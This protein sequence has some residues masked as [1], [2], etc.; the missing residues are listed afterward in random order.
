[1]I[2]AVLAIPGCV[3]GP[4]EGSVVLTIGK[5]QTVQNRGIA[6]ALSALMILSVVAVGAAA[7]TVDEADGDVGTTE[8]QPGDTVEVPS[9]SVWRRPIAS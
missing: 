2:L 5:K 1:V 3:S 7:Q 9:M 4:R 6:I 8:V